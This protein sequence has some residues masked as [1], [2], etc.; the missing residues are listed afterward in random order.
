[1]GCIVLSALSSGSYFFGWIISLDCIVS[2]CWIVSYCIGWIRNHWLLCTGWL[3][4][5]WDGYTG[6]GVGGT[7]VGRTDVSTRWNRSTTMGYGTGAPPLTLEGRQDMQSGSWHQ[8]CWCYK[9]TEYLCRISKI[10]QIECTQIWTSNVVQ[11][12]IKSTHD[13]IVL[14]WNTTINRTYNVNVSKKEIAEKCRY[15]DWRFRP[16]QS[17]IG[18]TT[19]PISEFLRTFTGQNCWGK[20]FLQSKYLSNADINYITMIAVKRAIIPF[21]LIISHRSIGLTFA[22]L[23]ITLCISLFSNKNLKS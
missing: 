3:L 4:P 17:G 11:E 22:V 1:M 18:G 20:V 6:W 21:I 7:G 19:V 16:L 8:L 5:G 15:K 9:Y 12:S 14:W 2:Y 13:T 10:I 23:K